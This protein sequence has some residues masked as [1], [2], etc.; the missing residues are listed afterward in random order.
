MANNTIDWLTR[1]RINRKISEREA[2]VNTK[3]ILTI[4]EAAGFHRRALSRS[5]GR[6]TSPYA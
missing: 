3:Y 6:A 1:I 2:L 5:E 4:I